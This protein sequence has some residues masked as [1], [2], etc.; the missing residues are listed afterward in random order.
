[1]NFSKIINVYRN[2]TKIKNLIISTNI[3]IGRK[4]FKFEQKKLLK[5]KIIFFKLFKYH[6]GKPIENNVHFHRN[7]TFPFPKQ[8]F[9]YRKIF[10]YKNMKFNSKLYFE[11]QKFEIRS[12]IIENHLLLI[13]NGTRC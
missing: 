1:M 4:P 7:Q 8:T 9:N 11:W 3:T 12:K 10:N 13:E 2:A 5:E 6:V